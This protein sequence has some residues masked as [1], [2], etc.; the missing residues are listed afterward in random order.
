MAV[1]GTAVKNWEELLSIFTMS[2]GKRLKLSI[3]RDGRSFTTI[4]TPEP[5]PETGVGYGGM[6]P[7]MKPLIG[8]VA[9]KWPAK[10]VGLKKGDLIKSVNGSPITHWAELEGFIHKDGSRKRFTVEREGTALEFDIAPVYNNEMKMYLVGISRQEELV[11]KRYGFLEAV[12]KGS[13]TA[14][15]MTGRLFTVIKGL[16]IGQYSIKYLGGPIMIAQVAGKAAES[17]AVDLLSLVA[18]LSLQLVI[19]NLFPIPVLDGG[20]LAFFF[21]E[22]VKG[23]PISEKIMTAAQQAG[24]AI[25]IALMALVTYNDIFRILR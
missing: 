24:I 7:D 5:S 4:L 12:L 23:S 14:V 21:I 3:E 2:P 22:S 13:S 18:F 1:D 6:Y 8:A 25:L 19:I 9:D 20:H 16:V 17:G 10:D 15:E 11:F